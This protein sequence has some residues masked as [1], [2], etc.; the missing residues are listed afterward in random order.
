[1]SINLSRGTATYQA[2]NFPIND[3]T[4]FANA[5]GD[6]IPSIPVVPA[7]VSFNVKWTAKGEPTHLPNKMLTTTGFSGLFQDSTAHVWWSA[8]QPA[9]NFRFVSDP[10][11]PQTTIS[12]VIGKEQNGVFYRPGG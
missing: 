9:A 4:N 2:T 3:Y 5:L 11:A 10:T 8:D 7:K 6:Q 12:G 1:M